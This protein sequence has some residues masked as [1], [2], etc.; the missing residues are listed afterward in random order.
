MSRF[1]SASAT[2][3]ALC[4]PLVAGYLRRVSVHGKSC[5]EDKRTDRRRKGAMFLQPNSQRGLNNTPT[6]KPSIIIRNA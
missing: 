3:S 2:T 1:V 4:L 5:I 6:S